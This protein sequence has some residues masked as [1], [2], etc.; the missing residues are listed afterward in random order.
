MEFQ[1]C[2]RDCGVTV[3][4]GTVADAGFGRVDVSAAAVRRLSAARGDEGDGEPAADPPNA[5]GPAE[6]DQAAG[7]AAVTDDGPAE[8]IVHPVPAE[9]RPVSRGESEP[10]PYEAGTNTLFLDREPVDDDD[11]ASDLCIMLRP[12]LRRAARLAWI[13]QDVARRMRPDCEDE[14]PSEEWVADASESLEVIVESLGTCVE[15][16]AADFNEWNDAVVNK[17]HCVYLKGD[18]AKW[19]EELCAVFPDRDARG[20]PLG[21]TRSRLVVECAL[22]V[23][24]YSGDPAKVMAGMDEM[25]GVYIN[26][27]RRQ[28]GEPELA[29]RESA[30]EP[31]TEPA[32]QVSV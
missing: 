18:A 20:G 26:L 13:A 2:L 4:K 25:A 29:A 23:L 24:K 6:R 7:P 5:T 21:I 3:H 16:L 22:K 12:G 28:S 17:R 10:L 32:A 31:A 30:T 27:K 15:Q 19:L 9:P 1:G 11:G 14:A 8:R